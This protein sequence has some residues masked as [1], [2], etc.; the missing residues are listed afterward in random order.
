MPEQIEEVDVLG[1]GS[2]ELRVGLRGEQAASIE[3]EVHRILGRCGGDV[4]RRRTG[5]PCE[6]QYGLKELRPDPAPAIRAADVEV[7]EL[8][9]IP[10]A[11]KALAFKDTHA[12]ERLG[13]ED[14]K[15]GS[16]TVEAVQQHRRHLLRRIRSPA[17]DLEVVRCANELSPVHLIYVVMDFG[18]IDGPDQL[19]LVS[20]Q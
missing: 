19:D 7:G 18:A 14:S 11:P 3:V 4:E 15:E 13:V 1:L 5:L 6:G 10:G 16:A 2:Q 17:R 20:P 8:Q 12:N 9:L